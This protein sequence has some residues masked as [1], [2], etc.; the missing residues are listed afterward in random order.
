MNLKALCTFMLAG[1]ILIGVPS[2]PDSAFAGKSEDA[3]LRQLQ[4]ARDELAAG[5]HNR[6]IKSAESALRF[7]PTTYEAIVIKALA[8]EA[9]GEPQLA[10]N[11]LVA[12]LEFTTGKDPDHRV[13]GAL[14]RLAE[15]EQ[16][17]RS[18][19]GQEEPSLPTLKEHKASTRA[20]IGVGR[21]GEAFVPARDFAVANPKDAGAHAVLGDVYRCAARQRQAGLQYR[22]AIAL[23]SKDSGVA[24]QLRNIEANLATIVL[25]LQAKS[26]TGIQVHVLFGAVSVA[27]T[28]FNKDVARFELLPSARPLKLT[29]G[30]RGFRDKEMPLAALTVGEVRQMRVLP[31]YVGVGSV[32]VSDWPPG[33]VDRVEIIERG[34]AILATPGQT[35]RLEAGSTSARITNRIGSFEV[36]LR[37]ADQ[38]E[39]R[40]EPGRW[41][42]AQAMVSGVPTGSTIEVKLGERSEEWVKMDVPP[43]DGVL[44]QVT[45]AFIAAPQRVKGLVAGQTSLRVRHPILGVG[46]QAITLTPA[47]ST[48]VVFDQSRLS[49][50]AALTKRWKEHKAKAGRLQLGPPSIGAMIGGGIALGLTGVF[51]GVS[52][53]SAGQEQGK[54]DAYRAAYGEGSGV[55]ADTREALYND[56]QSQRA[57]T[58]GTGAMAGVFAGIGVVGFGISIPLAVLIKPKN[59]KEGPVW[60]PEGF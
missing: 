33:G 25:E 49:E 24:K 44:D 3:A 15:V 40:L 13:S 10:E 59:K 7:D 29:I 23:G 41:M 4:F 43:G 42:P 31:T 16:V 9:I 26:L 1:L 17:K 21:C 19:R 20:L 54:E 38:Q 34:E 8:F 5:T 12:Y 51:A 46:A 32:S 58:Q 56:W 37:I 50:T 53:G 27:P 11:L 52:A 57:T 22:E 47:E 55:D 39:T 18:G 45:G 2:V 35:L 60:E 36:P 48:E 28:S 14:K 30:G 6:A